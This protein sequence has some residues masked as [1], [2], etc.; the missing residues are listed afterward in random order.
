[1]LSEQEK[2]ELKEMAAS[3]TLREEFRTLRNNSRDAES[4]VSLDELVC[5]LT[6]MSRICPNL[7][8]PSPFVHYTNVKI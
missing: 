4:R 7:A 2:Q 3:L 5:W 1:M 6:A 8:K